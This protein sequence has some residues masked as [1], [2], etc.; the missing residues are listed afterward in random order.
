MASRWA[1][2][3]A[4]RGVAPTVDRACSTSP[5]PAST[6]GPAQNKSEPAPNLDATL[7]AQRVAAHR[8]G[9]SRRL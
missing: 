2:S 9:L 3:T 8:V 1:V 6:P 7:P 4:I 5:I